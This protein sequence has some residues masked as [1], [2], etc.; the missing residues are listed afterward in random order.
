MPPEPATDDDGKVPW[1]SDSPSRPKLDSVGTGGVARA[2]LVGDG[3]ATAHRAWAARGGRG[4]HGGVPSTT[5]RSTSE[6]GPDTGLAF[7]TSARAG[8]RWQDRAGGC[9]GHSAPLRA[10]AC[11]VG[12]VPPPHGAARRTSRTLPVSDSAHARRQ[13]ARMLPRVPEPPAGHRSLGLSSQ[14]P[15]CL[16]SPP[17]LPPPPSLSSTSFRPVIMSERVAPLRSRSRPRLRSPLPP[18][19]L[20]PGALPT[21]SPPVP[22]RRPRRLARRQGSASDGS[23]ASHA[24]SDNSGSGDGGHSSGNGDAGSQ[25]PSGPT[26]PAQSQHPNAPTSQQAPTTNAPHATSQAATHQTSPQPTTAAGG[27][28][29]GHNS[30]NSGNDNDNGDG[31]DSI[32]NGATT[33]SDA[34][35]NNNNNNSDGSSSSSNNHN[36]NGNGNGGNTGPSTQVVYTTAADYSTN[37]S[38][39]T[40]EQMP[41]TGQGVQGG[42]PSTDADS[43]AQTSDDGDRSTAVVDHTIAAGSASSADSRGQSSA[44]SPDAPLTTVVEQT[45]TA[46]V[47]GSTITS[48]GLPAMASTAA[49]DSNSESSLHP[50]ASTFLSSSLSV[51]TSDITSGGSVVQI[52]GTQV[53]VVTATSTGY[54]EGRKSGPNGGLIGGVV[55]GVVGGVACLTLILLLLL[56][57]RR[58]RSRTGSAYFLCFGKRPLYGDKTDLNHGAGVNWPSFD[59]GRE[60]ALEMTD[61]ALPDLYTDEDDMIAGAAG[62]ALDPGHLDGHGEH[63]G[64]GAGA[65]HGLQHEHFSDTATTATMSAA[66]AN[67]KLAGMSDASHAY[68]PAA[69]D[70]SHL[71]PPEL[72][73]QRAQEAAA[74]AAASRSPL[75]PSEPSI[76]PHTASDS[77]AYVYPD[78]RYGA[79]SPASA[80]TSASVSSA[81]SAG[82]ALASAV[83]SAR[84]PVSAATAISSPSPPPPT[85]SSTLH[86][87]PHFDPYSALYTDTDSADGDPARKAGSMYAL[88]APMDTSNGAPAPESGFAVMPAAMTSAMSIPASAGLPAAPHCAW[89]PSL[90]LADHDRDQDPDHHVS[91]HDEHTPLVQFKP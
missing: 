18:A 24:P 55:G 61:A 75:H 42:N 37:A 83:T 6:G 71:D 58:R 85:G 41:T 70:Y 34:N 7:I 10:S 89:Q 23:S 13:C 29:N 79:Y 32:G 90:S 39:S 88:T 11:W 68:Y 40:Q 74:A 8:R 67:A 81:P 12:S 4:P 20:A 26:S 36:D 76:Q 25:Q 2:A 33:G 54:V 62:G 14:P 19:D 73:E 35:N 31:S 80:P 87:Y 59:P 17:P 53:V 64:A 3:G 72:R 30:S 1:R 60:A 82:V 28:S 45:Q 16:E 44:S 51:Y 5:V 86:S 65:A 15:V 47:G 69:P 27:N 84:A 9:R 63:A 46:V 77:P 91:E 38:P 49:T 43:E 22:R 21:P 57:L 52:T 50:S 56:L 48:V 66:N 78:T